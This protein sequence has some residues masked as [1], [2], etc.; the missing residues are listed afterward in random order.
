M[1]TKEFR[2]AFLTLVSTFLLGFISSEASPASAGVIS[3]SSIEQRIIRV[4]NQVKGHHAFQ[5]EASVHT[6]SP[7]TKS[8]T[9]SASWNNWN[10]YWNNWGNLPPMGGYRS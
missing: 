6:T 7:N 9:R 2:I 4:R 10:N 1:L 5:L 8:R 3:E